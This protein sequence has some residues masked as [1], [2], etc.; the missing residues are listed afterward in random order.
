[1]N[2][3]PMPPI[4]TPVLLWLPE[5]GRY[6]EAEFQIVGGKGVWWIARGNQWRNAE[7]E[8]EWMLMPDRERLIEMEN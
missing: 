7:P 1:V 6:T 8:L 4:A 5:L 2:D 3:L